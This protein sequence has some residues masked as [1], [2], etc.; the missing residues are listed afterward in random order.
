MF[1]NKKE[2][3]VGLFGGILLFNVIKL[4]SAASPN[5]YV[6]TFIDWVNS[7]YG[8]IFAAIL[9]TSAFDEY[10]F[11]KILVLFLI[12][13]VVWMVLKKSDVFGNNKPILFTIS[14]IVAILSVRFMKGDLFA[15]LLLP[16]GVLGATI[17]VF[18]P[19]LIYFLFTQTSIPGTTMKRAAWI[20][21]GV[22]FLVFMVMR[23]NSG[24]MSE[25]A[26]WVYWLGLIFILANVLFTRAIGGLMNRMEMA[27][28]MGAI[29]DRSKSEALAELNDAQTQYDKFQTKFNKNRL[30]RAIKRAQD[31]GVASA[32]PSI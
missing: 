17:M 32:L 30:R 21:Y 22:I 13:A 19:L 31:A 7:N 11:A 10:L 8:P 29:D 9:G 16:Y 14:A 27:R 26:Q 25:P 24:E 2:K 15:D 23:I 6:E 1:K 12:Y 3:I 18:L 28:A 4:V 20:V 5:Y